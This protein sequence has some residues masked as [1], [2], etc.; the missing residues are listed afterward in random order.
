MPEKAAVAYREYLLIDKSSD[1][2]KEARE[3]LED[4]EAPTHSQK[5]KE[6]RPVLDSLNVDLIVAEQVPTEGL[7]A[8]IIDRLRRASR[9]LGPGS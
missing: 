5:W 4:V 9:R 2:S 1:W 8:A 6:M 3:R 7:G